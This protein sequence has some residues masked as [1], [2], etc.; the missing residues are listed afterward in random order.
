M[1][2]YITVFRKIKRNIKMIKKITLTIFKDKVKGLIM[3]DMITT[4]LN[5]SKMIVMTL[6]TINKWM[7]I[8][9]PSK[10]Y[11]VLEIYL[12]IFLKL[13]KMMNI[14]REIEVEI[15]VKARGTKIIKTKYYIQNS[16]LAKTIMNLNNRITFMAVL[17]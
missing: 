4:F 3:E 11:S 1:K 7:S 16:R 13:K 8:N 12:I 17:F 6:N 9:K 2:Q 10:I 14:L 15:Q 5:N